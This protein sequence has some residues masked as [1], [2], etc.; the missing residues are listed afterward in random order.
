MT[1]P[2]PP[3]DSPAPFWDRAADDDAMWH[4]ATG[5]GHD[6]QQFFE[7]GRRET[8][9]LLAHT[10]IVPDRSSTVLEIGCG[11]GRMTSRLADHYGTV[12]ALDASPR[13][14]E[15]ARTTLA[16]RSNVTFLVGSGRD[17]AGVDTESV[18][19]VFSYLVLQ[20]IPDVE[21]QLNYL[22]ETRRV[23]RAGGVGA[24]QVRA[25]SPAARVLDWAGHLGH[26]L[27][28][29]RTLA[30]HWRGARLPRAAL[31]A[32]ASGQGDAGESD[33]ARGSAQQ[34]GPPASVELRPYGRRHLWVV[35]RRTAA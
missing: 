17:L 25:T 15:G 28:G 3:A 32:A 35:L 13:M 14:I 8:D 29:R 30:R 23:L 31:I 26:R 27:Q 1:T 24:L 18:D 19:V 21:A 10:G 5:V 12:I 20:H 22:R 11:I 9:A 33:G 34:S 16:G 4:I 6:P 7:S 2:P